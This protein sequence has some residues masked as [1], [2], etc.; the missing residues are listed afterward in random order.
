VWKVE[1]GIGGAQ[2]DPDRAAARPGAPVVYRESAPP[3]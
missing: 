2:A 3:F 1:L